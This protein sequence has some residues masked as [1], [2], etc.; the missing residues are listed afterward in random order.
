VKTLAIVA[1]Q[2]SAA[3]CRA[4]EARVPLSWPGALD[5]DAWYFSPELLSLYGTAAYHAL[6]ERA[7]RRLA[8]FEALNFFSLNIHGEAL[9]VAGLAE[10]VAAAESEVGRY[11]EH[12]IDEEHEH[13]A[14]FA[15][16]CA[17]YGRVYPPRTFALGAPELDAEQL[18]VLFFARAL[19]F[20][21]LVDSYN[22][23][24]AADP[25]VAAIAREINRRHHRDETRHLAFGRALLRELYAT[26]VS[27]WPP[28]ARQALDERVAAYTSSLWL[29]Y[30]NPSVYRDAGLDE[31]YELARRAV[32]DP[33]RE[34]SRAQLLARWLAL[35]EELVLTV[36]GGR[37]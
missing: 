11:L 17:R 35:R 19:I 6:D 26:R 10:R 13:T 3:S 8:R 25:R 28:A 30:A 34:P 32:A 4:R 14:M 36:Q 21:E 24:V 22:R 5:D 15:E 7:R 18:D 16:F 1:K 27:R 37:A 20:E 29:E 31:P 23:C 12:F 9:L 33:A 2:L